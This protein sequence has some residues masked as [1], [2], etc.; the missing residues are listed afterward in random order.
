M[1]APTLNRPA[2]VL[3]LGRI[4]IRA[5]RGNGCV[6]SLAHDEQR[7]MFTMWAIARSPL[8]FG[9]DLATLDPSTRGRLSS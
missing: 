6:S 4:G 8:M 5:Q 3:P 1:Q 2:D 9:G 7:T